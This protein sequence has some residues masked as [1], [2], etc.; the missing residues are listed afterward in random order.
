MLLSPPSLVFV[1]MPKCKF[2]SSLVYC[3]YLQAEHA[4]ML[5]RFFWVSGEWNIFSLGH[6]VATE[7]LPQFH[8]SFYA[9][10]VYIAC[11]K[12]GSADWLCSDK[13]SVVSDPASHL[14]VLRKVICTSGDS[15]W[16]VYPLW[17]LNASFLLTLIS[18]EC[19]YRC[20]CEKRLGCKRGQGDTTKSLSFFRWRLDH[21][22]GFLHRNVRKIKIYFCV[23]NEAV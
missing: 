11:E 6:Q 8:C 7:V 4:G 5:R 21:I 3:D 23:D 1:V 17:S 16:D 22:L 15:C 18:V 12:C 13:S 14:L 9:E 20:L 19:L 10:S 2:V